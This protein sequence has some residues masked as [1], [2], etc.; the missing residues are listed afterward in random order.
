MKV[1]RFLARI[2][3][4]RKTSGTQRADS[5]LNEI[6]LQLHQIKLYYIKLKRTVNA[7]MY[8]GNRC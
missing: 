1:P 5:T 4:G 7:V 3:R 8:Q 2:A 6:K